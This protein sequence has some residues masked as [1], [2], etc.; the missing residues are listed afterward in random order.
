MNLQIIILAAGQGKRMFSNTPKVLHPLAGKPMLTRVVE[1]ALQLKPESIHV[2]YGHGGEHIKNS[3]PELPVH[4]VKQAEQL[5]TGHAVMQA[6]PHIPAHAQ[7][8]VLSADVPLIQPQTL[9]TLVEYSSSSTSQDSVLA[10]LV[11]HLENPYGLG[12]IL[13]NNEGEIHAIV[14]EKDANEQEKNV[15]EIYSGICCAKS[16]DLARW[17]PMLNNDNAQGEY[18][19]TEIISMAVKNK[20]AI[21]SL[22]APNLYEIQGV[23]NRLQLQQLERIWQVKEAERLL[24]AGVGIA[25]A[26]RF[27]L[28]GELTCGKDVF[29]D[30]NCVFK[31]KVILGDGVIIGPNCCLTD[32]TVGAGSEIFPHSVIEQSVLGEGCTVGPFARLRPGTELA[33]ECKIG[34]FVETKNAVFDTGSKASH[35]SYLGDV[36]IGKQVNIGAGTITCNY[37]GANKHQT[38]I[39]DGVFIGSDTQLVAPVTIGAHATIGAGSTIRKNV[40]AGELTLTE[41]KQRTVDGWKRPVKKKNI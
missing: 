4:W 19:L 28:R 26:A 10:L 29:I 9:K 24:E 3:L 17:L 23:N 40:P 32:V 18:Y 41:S 15:K 7:V 27:D 30:V 6:L 35:L 16:S 25:D 12:R 34:N 20:V 31:G 39:E 5:G 1:T 2:I 21:T 33:A 22:D 14:E 37:D 36:T 11:A 38:V 13:R 8:L